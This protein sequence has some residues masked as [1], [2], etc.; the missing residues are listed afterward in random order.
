MPL[1]PFFAARAAFAVRTLCPFGATGTGPPEAWLFDTSVGGASL[2]LR[3]FGAAG[4][5][6]PE[7]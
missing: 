7:V 5:R 3:L 1:F 2:T 6:P 4:S